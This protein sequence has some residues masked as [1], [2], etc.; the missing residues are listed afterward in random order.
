MDYN[1]W[2]VISMHMKYIAQLIEETPFAYIF[3]SGTCPNP[4]HRKFSKPS[5]IKSIIFRAWNWA[6]VGRCLLQ[7]SS[8]RDMLCSRSGFKTHIH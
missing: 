4:V 5:V 1:V 2:V 7:G 6:F 3:Q 8:R